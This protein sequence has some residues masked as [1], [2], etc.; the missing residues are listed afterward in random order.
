[1]LARAHTFAVDGLEAHRVCVEFDLRPGLPAFNIIGL[2]EASARS[3]RE[4][5]RAAL[6]NSGFTFPRQRVTANLAPA[7]LEKAGSGFDLALA[8]GLL[9]ASDQVA[10]GGLDGIALFAELSLSG[11]LRP[12][13]GVLAAAEAAGREALRG[14]VVARANAA[15]ATQVDGLAVAG[16]RSLGEVAGLLDGRRQLWR[17]PVRRGRRRPGGAGGGGRAGRTGRRASGP[18]PTPRRPRRSRIWPMYGASG[19]RSGR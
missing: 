13:R 19:R 14:L 15:E 17:Q 9:A 7:P 6:L 10:R 5:V 16:V 8:C 1:M 2:P 11:E 4:R 18:R 12:C 3:S